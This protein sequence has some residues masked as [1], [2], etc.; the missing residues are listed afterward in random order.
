MLLSVCFVAGWLS[1]T[2]VG[3]AELN[4]EFE[5]DH[6]LA[7]LQSKNNIFIVETTSVG[8]AIYEIPL[9]REKKVVINEKFYYKL[10]SKF[11]HI[12]KDEVPIKMYMLV[13]GLKG[14]SDKWL[15]DSIIVK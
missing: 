14:M 9:K 6:P 1:F 3:I 7:I 2:S 15:E 10:G 8:G 4:A 11:A 13:H 5:C 12:D